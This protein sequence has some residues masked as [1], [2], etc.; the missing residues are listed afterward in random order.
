MI[1]FDR[2]DSSTLGFAVSC[3]SYGAITLDE[4]HQWIVQVLDQNSDVPT[5]LVDLL[6]F[7]GPLAKIYGVIGFTPSWPY[8]KDAKT[9]LLAIA[10]RRGTPPVDCQIGSTESEAKLARYPQV[11]TRF[12]ELF[13]FVRLNGTKT[14]EGSSPN[15][16]E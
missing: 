3:L 16:S 14:E 7:Q 5:L 6:D 13:P 2:K 15:R 11:E 1:G 4:F 12:K 8:P 9:A 10:Y